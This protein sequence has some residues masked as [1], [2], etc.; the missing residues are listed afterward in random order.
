NDKSKELFLKM[1]AEGIIEPWRIREYTK[2]TC[3]DYHSG[4]WLTYDK[5][6]EE[7]VETKCP[8]NENALH[9]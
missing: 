8:Y 7:W 9:N 4:K 2:N 6:N 3:F 5:I 1:C